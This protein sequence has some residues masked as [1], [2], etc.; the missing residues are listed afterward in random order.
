MA[1]PILVCLII[2]LA[3][4]H[5]LDWFFIV[6]TSILTLASVTVVPLVMEQR[7]GLWTLGTFTG[8]LT[9]LL[10]TCCIYSRGDWFFVAVI[11]VLFGLSVLFAPF[12][13]RALP[14][15]GFAAQNKGLLVM[16]IDTVLLFAIVAVSGLYGGYGGDFWRT[17]IL[18]TTCPVLFP[19][20]L[21]LIIRYLK[22]NGLVKAG[23]CTVFGGVF[24]SMFENAM[25]LING[26]PMTET[27]TKA[28]L[29]VWQDDTVDANVKL[30]ILITGLIVGG[31][32]LILGLIR[33]KK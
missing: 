30:I 32:L 2:N 11:P 17:A 31:I 8:S 13:A 5:A 4:G 9:L 6:L 29:F 28:N 24:I 18:D 16:M 15:K 21:F 33:K 25:K 3:T 23:L 7:K 12:V 27:L 19:W 10:L 26:F 22:Q 20:A 1:I 14:L